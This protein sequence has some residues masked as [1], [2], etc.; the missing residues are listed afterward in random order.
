M[1]TFL[2]VFRGVPSTV[3]LHTYLVLQLVESISCGP[4][5]KLAERETFLS[6]FTLKLSITTQTVPKELLSCCV[7]LSHQRQVPYTD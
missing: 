6:D 1:D 5:S 7:I 2:F 4:M 3:L